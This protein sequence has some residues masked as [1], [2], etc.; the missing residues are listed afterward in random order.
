MHKRRVRNR[1]PGRKESSINLGGS[2][3]LVVPVE[4][5]SSAPVAP[6]PF[7]SSASAYCDFS[8]HGDSKYSAE[9][10]CDG[11]SSPQ[12]NGNDELPIIMEAA[13]IEA[14]LRL[15]DGDCSGNI[16]PVPRF[17]GSEM[18]A[19]SMGSTLSCFSINGI[20]LQ[21]QYLYGPAPLKSKYFLRR[22]VLVGAVVSRLRPRQL[23]ALSTA[24]DL[25][26]HKW[27]W[28]GVLFFV[29]RAAATEF[30]SKSY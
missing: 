15:G 26:S 17:D 6:V 20:T 1:R 22:R 3:S 10:L 13:R 16:Y 5:S 25:W 19:W 28:S 9:R 23:L 14:A 7:S 4:S 12:A 30:W 2:K 21:Q 24:L 27:A 11:A 8:G 18:D 29:P